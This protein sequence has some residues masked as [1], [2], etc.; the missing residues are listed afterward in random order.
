MVSANRGFREFLRYVLPT[1]GAMLS[2]SAYTM[3]SGIIVAKGEGE[4][5][6]AAL[7][8][9]M[10]L[11]NM[12]FAVSV[13]FSVG[14]STVIGIYKGKG[15]TRLASDV[16]S[17][18]LFA[19]LILGFV[20][21]LLT[22]LFPRDIARFLGG[23]DLTIDRVE[24]FVRVTG[25][26]S[27]A[28]LVSYNLEVMSRADGRPN[29]AF[30]GVLAGGLVTA[31][32][33]WLFVIHLKK[34]MTGAALAG[35]LGQLASILVYLT[36]FLS[37]RA[38]LK[39][40]FIKPIKGLFKRVLSLGF[41]EFSNEG[42]LALNAFAYNRAL[43]AVV[44]ERGVVGYAVISYVNTLVVMLLAGIAQANQPLVSHRRGARDV[45]GMFSF[46]GYGIGTALTLGFLAFG[47]CLI[48]APDIVPLLVEESSSAFEGTVNALRMFAVAFPLM[49]INIVTSGFF[50]AT[51][52]PVQSAAISLGRGVLLMITLF[53]LAV[54]HA[55]DAIWYA[56]AIAEGACAITAMALLVRKKQKA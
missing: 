1:T 15:D 56:A 25:L 48:F 55:A 54:F 28:Y 23:T 41:S 26:F 30:L 8:L 39:L 24:Q 53:T 19:L 4:V 37:K 44:G 29:M 10:P 5:A 42:V 17:Q 49:G 27:A 18:D 2:F 22:T 7:N 6:L 3:I 21:T 20:F 9:S 46:Y 45:K 52:N 14:A 31:G 32:L 36:H 40:T 51:E 50:A 33:G 38:K 47:A 16:F 34:G 12:L 43:L 35:G 13:F 11:V